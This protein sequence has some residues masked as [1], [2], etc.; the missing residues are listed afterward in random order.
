MTEKKEK[1]IG[2]EKARM[3][4]YGDEGEKEERKK[5]LCDVSRFF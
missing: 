5:L 3:K 2:K 4:E 1:Y